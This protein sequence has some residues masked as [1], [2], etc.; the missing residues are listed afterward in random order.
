MPTW[1][2][3]SGRRPGVRASPARPDFAA[4]CGFPHR[5]CPE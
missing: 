1:S 4:P 2:A 5:A 3:S